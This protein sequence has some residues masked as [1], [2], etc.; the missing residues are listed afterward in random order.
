MDLR[1]ALFIFNR[2]KIVLIG[3]LCGCVISSYGQQP[4]GKPPGK[5][6]LTE[7]AGVVLS[8]LDKDELQIMGL[9]SEV[10]A[11]KGLVASLQGQAVSDQAAMRALQTSL[12]G[13]QTQF[14]NHYHTLTVLTGGGLSSGGWGIFDVTE[15]GGPTITV[16]LKFTC[17]PGADP[18]CANLPKSS[19]AETTSKPLQAGPQ[20][21]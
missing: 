2:T 13:L 12:T 4:E 10:K 8:R 5:I 21:Q 11:L 7:P 18:R 1:T 19:Y 6:V 9:Q 16:G 20:G 17:V 15:H 14:A 3:L